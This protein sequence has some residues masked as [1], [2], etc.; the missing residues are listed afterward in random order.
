MTRPLVAILDVTTKE[1]VVREMNDAEYA[2]HLLDIEETPI[3]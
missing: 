1:T 2:Q 3:D